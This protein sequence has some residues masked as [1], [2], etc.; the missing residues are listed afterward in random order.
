MFKVFPLHL[1]ISN[2][3]GVVCRGLVED[4]EVI[5]EFCLVIDDI[6]FE[7]EVSKGGVIFVESS[8]INIVAMLSD[9]VE[10]L[11]HSGH[12]VRKDSAIAFAIIAFSA[13]Y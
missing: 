13:F 8:Y 5:I 4:Y 2:N 7:I 12:I 9:V 1:R 6:R 10:E 3:R 11:V